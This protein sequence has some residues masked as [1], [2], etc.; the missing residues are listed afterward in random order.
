MQAPAFGLDAPGAYGGQQPMYMPQQPG[1]GMQGAQYA[2]QAPP[3]P[4]APLTDEEKKK[5]KR[6]IDR[7]K[8]ASRKENEYKK[9]ADK[10]VQWLVYGNVV[11]ALLLLIPMFGNSWVYQKFTG[12]GL[13]MMDI[14]TSLFFVDVDVQCGKNWLEDKLCNSFGKKIH[15]SHSLPEAGHLACSVYANNAC[16]MVTVTYYCSFIIFIAFAFSILFS[17][18]GALFLHFYWHHNQLPKMRNVSLYMLVMAPFWSAAGLVTWS[19]VVPDIGELPRGWLSGMAGIPGA[20]LFSFKEVPSF[21]Y[22]WSWCMAILVV[23]SQICVFMCWPIYFS[24]GQGEDDAVIAELDE[25]ERLDFELSYGPE[26]T[27]AVQQPGA[28]QQQYPPQGQPSAYD[29]YGVPQGEYGS[30]QQY[31]GAPQYG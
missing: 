28:V 3:A 30:S 23:F 11:N 7:Q 21:P 10:T 19:I 9:D 31:G 15:G 18:L 13:K 6:R 16:G 17:F 20:E 24:R 5:M 26:P 4:Q 27:F 29:P 2:A 14:N 1:Y 12:I 8:L 25:Q 22:G